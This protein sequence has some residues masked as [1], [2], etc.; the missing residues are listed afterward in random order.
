M[1]KVTCVTCFQLDRLQ[2]GETLLVQ[3]Q[4]Q[5]KA[6]NIDGGDSKVRH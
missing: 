4:S 6:F 1:L 5:L 3:D 2:E